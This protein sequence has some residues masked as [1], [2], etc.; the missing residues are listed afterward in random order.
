SIGLL[1][2]IGMDTIEASVL[3]NVQFLI[4]SFNDQPDIQILSHTRAN[5]FGG[6][7]TFKKTGVETTALYQYLVDKG[8]L[9]APRGGGIRFSPHFHTQREQLEAVVDYVNGY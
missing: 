4:N 5:R 6:I 7:F 3:G 1:L 9:C 2:D 8:V